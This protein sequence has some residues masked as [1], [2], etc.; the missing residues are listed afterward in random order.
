MD[1]TRLPGRAVPGQNRLDPVD[2]RSATKKG[3]NQVVLVSG[4]ALVIVIF[5]ALYF[6]YFA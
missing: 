4:L 6:V 3:N 5:A 2:A 1:D